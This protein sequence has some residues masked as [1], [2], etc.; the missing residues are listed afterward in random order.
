MRVG[1]A[2]LG[3]SISWKIQQ[4]RTLNRGS[5]SRKIT[6]EC[7]QPELSKGIRLQCLTESIACSHLA[8][9]GILAPSLPNHQSP[10]S[11]IAYPLSSCPCVMKAN[12]ITHQPPASY[13]SPSF[14]RNSRSCRIACS[15]RIRC[16]RARIPPPPAHLPGSHTR[17]TQRSAHPRPRVMK[18]V[19]SLSG[20][21]ALQQRLMYGRE[22]RLSG[23]GALQQLLMYER[24]YRLSG[25]GACAAIPHPMRPATRQR[26]PDFA[27]GD[28]ISIRSR[29]F[30]ISESPTSR[31]RDTADF[32]IWSSDSNPRAAMRDAARAADW[33]A[34]MPAPSRRGPSRAAA[35]VPGSQPGQ[36]RRSG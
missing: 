15:L 9:K 11:C 32:A 12:F 1:D 14:I 8:A 4:N 3:G 20:S 7:K 33:R 13:S 35:R 16:L 6:A 26:I 10:A 17:L 27:I 25:S 5:I 30:M 19:Y 28:R 22:Y 36:S 31:L 2:G 18:M 21:G 23:S 24:E 34:C 29:G